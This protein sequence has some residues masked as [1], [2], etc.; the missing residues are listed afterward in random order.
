MK[1]CFIDKP[2]DKVDADFCNACQKNAGYW[3]ARKKC[4]RCK[5]DIRR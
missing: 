2:H 4:P 5:N 3:C 1:C